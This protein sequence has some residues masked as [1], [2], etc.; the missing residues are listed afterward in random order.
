MP[1]ELVTVVGEVRTA[2][3]LRTRGG[4][5]DFMASIADGTG[6][7]GCYFFGQAFLARTLRPGTRWS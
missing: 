1:G 7:L 4:R 3:A 2:A 5:T 6:T